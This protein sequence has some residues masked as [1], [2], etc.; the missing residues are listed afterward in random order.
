MRHQQFRCSY[1]DKRD[2]GCNRYAI[3]HYTGE[4]R[5]FG[6]WLVFELRQ[7][8]MAAGSLGLVF[9]LVGF[10]NVTG[11]VRDGWTL[12]TS[13]PV[14]G[15]SQISA[16][17]ALTLGVAGLTQLLLGLCLRH[18]S[19]R[20][21]R[22]LLVS[23]AL[24]AVTWTLTGG[25]MALRIKIAM[26]VPGAPK[27][28]LRFLYGLYLVSFGAFIGSNI[29]SIVTYFRRSVLAFYTAIVL[30][31]GSLTGLSVTVVMM[32]IRS[33]TAAVIP[34]LNVVV[35]L[36]LLTFGSRRIVGFIKRIGTDLRV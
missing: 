5:C 31:A 1:V 35:I 26:A 4:A 30:A 10:W 16:W 17:D 36:G 9:L 12:L 27:V 8:G 14:H 29:A 2:K 20:A 18:E 15:S 32:T 3:E 6:H 24:W 33:G 11:A 28:D 25:L 34:L 13:T 19:A 22:W 7:N 23:A 21:G